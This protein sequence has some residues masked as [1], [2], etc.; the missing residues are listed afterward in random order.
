MEYS[1]DLFINQV[2]ALSVPAGAIVF[3]HKHKLFHARYR[4]GVLFVLGLGCMFQLL[5]FLALLEY[6][7]GQIAWRLK[8]EGVQTTALILS[9]REG[10]SHSRRFIKGHLNW[11]HYYDAACEYTDARGERL[12]GNVELPPNMPH[13]PGD[14]VLIRYLPSDSSVMREDYYLARARE[15]GKWVFVSLPWIA[16]ALLFA[17]IYSNARRRKRRAMIAGRLDFPY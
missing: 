4:M 5:F 1:V 8:Q 17:L 13:L 14:K 2:A 15:P 3:I 10:G 6:S 12:K 9:S 7:E 16:N 11:S